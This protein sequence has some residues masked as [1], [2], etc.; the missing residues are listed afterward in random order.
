MSARGQKRPG[1][2]QEE[3]KKRPGG[4]QE[5]ARKREQKMTFLAMPEFSKY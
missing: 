4:D 3:A 2:G 1:R 5:E